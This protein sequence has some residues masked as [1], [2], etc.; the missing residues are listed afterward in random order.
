MGGVVGGVA[1]VALIVALLFFRRRW[2]RKNAGFPA[3]LPSDSSKPP[4]EYQQVTMVRTPAELEQYPRYDL[5]NAVTLAPYRRA[6]LET[7]S[8]RRAEVPG[9]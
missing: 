4:P 6:E 8:N 7:E 2:R 5:P 9:E 1:L 3:E